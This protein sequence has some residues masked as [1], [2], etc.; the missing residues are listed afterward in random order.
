[1]QAVDDAQAQPSGRQGDAL[2]GS[3]DFK[4]VT[5]TE[6]A[7]FKG[8]TFTEVANF[9]GATFTDR[10]NFEGATFTGWANFEGATFTE[11]A[12]FKGA[13]FTEWADFEGATFI[14]SADFRGATFTEPADFKK[15]TFTDWVFFGYA[16]F[17]EGA[18]FEGAIFTEWAIF[19]GATFTKAAIFIGATFT[20]A[21]DFATATF[22]YDASFASAKFAG[23]ADFRRTNFAGSAGFSGTTFTGETSFDEASFTTTP[24]FFFG[25]TLH[26]GTSWFGIVWPP[27]PGTEAKARAAVSAYERLKLEM[28]RLK[29]H[30]DELNFFALELQAR[31]VLLGK[32][33][34]LQGLSIG[35]YGFLSDYGRSYSRPLLLLGTIALAGAV[36]FTLHFGLPGWKGSLALSVANTL[37]VFGL[38]TVFFP[39]SVV[40]ELPSA[41]KLLSGAQTVAG[42]V[43]CFLVGL[44]MRNRFRMR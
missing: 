28:D 32:W 36:P 8:V 37:G 30:E 19:M 40:I 6:A 27:P 18:N 14:Q 31:R 43:L 26:E 16:T 42:A 10:A 44:G 25:A 34:T 33:L 13:T 38:R 22:G 41:L 29:K 17:T 39:P 11:A 4:G 21:A 2:I 1:V 15:A 7:D 24:P 5:F 20:E 23:F 3:V 9:K 12:N 35:A